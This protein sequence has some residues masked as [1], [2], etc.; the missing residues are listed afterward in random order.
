MK[1]HVYRRGKTWTYKYDG[2]PDP[3]TGKRR[4]ITKGGF[5]SER[6]AWRAVRQAIADVEAGRFVTPSRRT[7]GD[8]LLNDW[9]P[10]VRNSLKPSTLASY[11]DYIRAY[12]IPAL[13]SVKLQTL[14]AKRCNAFYEH[15]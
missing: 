10:M 4:M 2:P 15:C 1:G 13:G 12:V 7:L 11:E 6:E 9:L 14:D 3:L 8:F 5:P